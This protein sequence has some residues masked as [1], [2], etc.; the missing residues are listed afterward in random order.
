MKTTDDVL[1]QVEKAQKAGRR[2]ILLL[3]N[4]GGGNAVIV[5]PTLTADVMNEYRFLDPPTDAIPLSV[6]VSAGQSFVVSLLL[7]NQSAGGAPFAPSVVYDQDGCQPGTNAVDVIPG[8]W[9]DACPLGVTGD[10]VIRAVVDCDEVPV[11]LAGSGGLLGLGVAVAA[12]GAAAL[13]RRVRER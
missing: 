11:P 6:P 4:Q 1:K 5:A 2:S 9:S 10:W 12:S 3:V 7:L 8:G 13:Q